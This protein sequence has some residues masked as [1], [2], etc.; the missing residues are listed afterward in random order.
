M[1]LVANNKTIRDNTKKKKCRLDF[2]RISTKK[3]KKRRTP[4]FKICPKINKVSVKCW[5][6]IY[7]WYQLKHEFSYVSIYQKCSSNLG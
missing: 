6:K 1:T 5:L 7:C 4:S 3:D 2:M